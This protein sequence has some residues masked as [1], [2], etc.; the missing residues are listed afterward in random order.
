MASTQ[1]GPTEPSNVEANSQSTTSNEDDEIIVEDAFKGH[2]RVSI[3]KA[4]E[5]VNAFNMKRA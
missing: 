4:G 1:T 5:M 3:F 2:S